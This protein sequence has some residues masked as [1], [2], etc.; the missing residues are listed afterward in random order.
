MGKP[1]VSMPARGSGKPA[2]TSRAGSCLRSDHGTEPFKNSQGNCLWAKRMHYDVAGPDLDSC[3][4]RAKTDAEPDQDISCH[5][6]LI[7]LRQD[8][9]LCTA[10]IQASNEEGLGSRT[11]R[12]GGNHAHVSRTEGTGTPAHIKTCQSGRQAG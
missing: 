3:T 6:H 1:S 10:C 7:A 11:S 9:T 8:K 12:T 5:I 4:E 2:Q